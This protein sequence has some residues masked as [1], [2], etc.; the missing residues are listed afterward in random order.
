MNRTDLFYTEIKSA[1]NDNMTLKTLQMAKH[2]SDM[3]IIHGSKIWLFCKKFTL[4]H[5]FPGCVVF[6]IAMAQEMWT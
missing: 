5:S 2:V 3:K 6:L 1:I 4:E